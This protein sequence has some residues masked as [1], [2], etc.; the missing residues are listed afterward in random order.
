MTL[1]YGT[2]EEGSDAGYGERKND[3]QEKPPSWVPMK[4]NEDDDE[5]NE[6]T[7]WHAIAKRLVVVVR[8][9][10]PSQWWNTSR[11]HNYGVGCDEVLD[12]SNANG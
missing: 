7:K 9:K 1:E 8:R 2:Q 3:V 6:K 5:K 4:A 12:A 11:V 10:H